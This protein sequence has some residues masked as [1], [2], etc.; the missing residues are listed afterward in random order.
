MSAQSEI[1]AYLVEQSV[2]VGRSTVLGALKEFRKIKN[3]GKAPTKREASSDSLRRAVYEQQRGRCA[4]PKCRRKVTL[5]KF[6]VDHYEPL[7]DGGSNSNENR[8]GYCSD[9]NLAK[10]SKDPVEWSKR[11]GTTILESMPRNNDSI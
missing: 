1:L 10:S 11:T 6:H 7:A 4:N 8:H 2:A 5:S 9:C 3:P